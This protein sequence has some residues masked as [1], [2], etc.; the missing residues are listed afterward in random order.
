MF[1]L[2]ENVKFVFQSNRGDPIN[3]DV[4]K[5][6]RAAL[7]FHAATWSAAQTWKKEKNKQIVKNLPNDDT[8][9]KFFIHSLNGLVEN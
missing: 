1:D 9:L 6:K 7:F 5:E 3:G 8:D 4:A 2:N